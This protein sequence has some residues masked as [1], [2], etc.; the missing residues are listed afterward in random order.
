MNYSLNI[1]EWNSVFAVPSSV[2]DKYIKLAGAN[3]LKLLLFLLRHGGKEYTADKLK[4][5]LGF[6]ETGELEDAALFWIQRGV[7][8]Y[9][10]DEKATFSAAPE[11]PDRTAPLP[12]VKAVQTKENFSQQEEYI[13]PTIDDI[14]PSKPAEKPVKVSPARVS[15]GE[16]ASRIKNSDEV[17][18]LFAEAEKIYGRPLRQ[19]DNQTVIALVDHYGLP[20]GVALM[21][22][23]YCFK[24][25]KGTP[26]FIEL[27]ASGWSADGIDSVEKADAR[28]RAL[29]KNN[30]TEAHIREE[31]GISKEFSNKEK[32]LLRVW[33]DNW[34]FS[35]DMIK[36]AI[37]KT[38]DSKGEFIANYANKILEN[39]KKDNIMITEK[40]EKTE[41]TK[42]GEP[43][44]DG[45]SSFSTG[46]IMSDL[47]S[48]YK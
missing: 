41:P 7:L 25:N 11:E 4:F 18:M 34:G 33:S 47:I 38:I 14:T 26:H 8:R 1:G 5:E 44:A 9:S 3:S 35:E 42:P 2:V 30:E 45:D 36:L 19:R 27:T 46:S 24:V 15:S 12:S 16:I 40:A 31:F 37:S 23:T 32:T 20:V 43:V 13:Q 17:R 21:L 29:E 10:N 39:W 6:T 28:I 22:L 48:N